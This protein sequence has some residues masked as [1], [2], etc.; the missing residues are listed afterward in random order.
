MHVAMATIFVK[1]VLPLQLSPDIK[2]FFEMKILNFNNI[3]YNPLSLKKTLGKVY[4]G[5]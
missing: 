5:K 2:L 3:I 4:T 1:F